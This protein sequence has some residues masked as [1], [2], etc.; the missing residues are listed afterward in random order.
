[1]TAAVD[2][3]QWPKWVIHFLFG[4]YMLL[5]LYKTGCEC[6]CVRMCVPVWVWCACICVC[7]LQFVLCT[8]A[9]DAYHQLARPDRARP[10]Q[11]RPGRGKS[12]RARSLHCFSTRSQ[13]EKG[14]IGFVQCSSCCPSV[15][16]HEARD[17]NLKVY[18]RRIE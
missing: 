4:L 13:S 7:F 15:E 17:S 2:E 3:M 18:L 8:C 9:R 1:M 12:F 10:D 11:A 16:T 6:V 14:Y 5:C